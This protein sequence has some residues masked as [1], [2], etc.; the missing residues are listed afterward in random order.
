[1]VAVQVMEQNK[2]LEP[3]PLL[4][5]SKSTGLQ[6]VLSNEMFLYLPTLNQYP[7]VV[8]IQTW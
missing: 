4:G 5:L 7:H 8:Q 2:Q 3:A 6:P 1:M